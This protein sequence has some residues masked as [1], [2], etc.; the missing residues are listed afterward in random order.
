M[1]GFRIIAGRDTDRFEAGDRIVGG[2]VYATALFE[3]GTVERW[4]GYLRNVLEAMAVN[5]QVSVERLPLLSPLE[6]LQALV[7]WNA[8]ETEYPQGQCLH[9]L[10]ECVAA[11]R[12]DAA[13]VVWTTLSRV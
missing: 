7:E 3:R 11:E 10:F 9:E 5:D 8:T 4:C 1:G 2:L 6:R 13:A 12:P